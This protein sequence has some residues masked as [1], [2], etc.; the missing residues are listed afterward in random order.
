ERC[1]VH[2]I[3]SDDPVLLLMEVH[4]MDPAAAAVLDRPYFWFSPLRERERRAHV[5]R[6]VVDRPLE[7]AREGLRHRVGKEIVETAAS[8][9]VARL[10]RKAVDRGEVEH[11]F[12]ASRRPQLEGVADDW[13]RQEA[14]FARDLGETHRLLSV[15]K[16]VLT[17]DTRRDFR[18]ARRAH[19]HE[20]VSSRDRG[21]EEAESVFAPLDL[22][23]RVRL[24]VDG[25]DVADE[26]MI[27]E[28][29]EVRLSP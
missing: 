9:Q 12:L 14:A 8:L 25:E 4:R 26:A 19:E 18:T 5:E 11:H 23:N 20:L 10:V 27:R 2:T 29:A 22:E 17:L 16:L 28:M 6:P 13:K 7:F 3:L 1:D 15:R 24:A 21:I